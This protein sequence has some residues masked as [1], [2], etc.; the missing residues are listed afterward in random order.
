MVGSSTHF[1]NTFQYHYFS[2]LSLFEGTLMGF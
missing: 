2:T 1:I